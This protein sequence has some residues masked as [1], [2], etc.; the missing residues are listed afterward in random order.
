MLNHFFCRPFPSAFIYYEIMKSSCDTIHL[1][2]KVAQ[3]DSHCTYDFFNILSPHFCRSDFIRL[4]STTSQIWNQDP[5]KTSK[6][7]GYCTIIFLPQ[8]YSFYSFLPLPLIL[9]YPSLF[10]LDNNMIPKMSQYQRK[11]RQY[12]KQCKCQIGKNHIKCW[13]AMLIMVKTRKE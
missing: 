6:T 3:A 9:P 1:S 11:E 5:P 4:I 12:H 10:L 13:I 7:T 2:S 8:Q